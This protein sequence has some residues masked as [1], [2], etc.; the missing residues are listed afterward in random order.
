MNNVNELE[1]KLKKLKK[2]NLIYSIL[3]IV[4]VILIIIG[5]T[6]NIQNLNGILVSIG[7]ISIIVFSS[8]NNNINNKMFK[9]KKE[10]YDINTIRKG[11][12]DSKN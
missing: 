1:L 5:I 12:E 3:I 9:V 8:L 11:I 10:I 2:L 7:T 4:S 6:C